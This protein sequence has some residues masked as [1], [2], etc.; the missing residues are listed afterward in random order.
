M[1]QLWENPKTISTI[2]LNADKNDIKKNMANFIVNNLYDNISSLHQKDEQIIYIVTLLLKEEINSLT[3]INNSFLY[4]TC[5]GLILKEFRKRKEVK[6]FFKKI[7][8][9]MIEQFEN[10]YSSENII[11]ET[12][13]IREVIIN[14]LS[15]SNNKKSDNVLD[16]KLNHDEDNKELELFK[17]KYI[18]RSLDKDKINDE[19]IKYKDKDMLEYLLKIINGM[20]SS[21]KYLNETFLQDI[22]SYRESDT[23]MEY[24][25]NSFSQVVDIIDKFFDNLINNIDLCPYSIKCFCKIISILI[26]KKFPKSIKVEQNRFLVIYFFQNLLF[27]MLM[28]PGLDAFINE[29]FI[30]KSINNKIKTI[31]N[32]LNKLLRGN[33]Y[34]KS[35]FTPF[36]WYIIEKM[37]KILEFFNTIC[38]VSLPSF[39]DK[40][41]ND[42]LPE[43]YKYDYFKENPNKTILYRNICFN[44][45]ELYSLVINSEK[46]K[47]KLSIIEQ[48]VLS[49]FKIYIKNLEKLKN[50]E[51]YEEYHMADVSYDIIEK[52][53]IM[54]Y[55]LLTDLINNK[56]FDKILNLQKYNKN[57]FRL[58]ELKIIET[59]EQKIENNIIK[60]KNFFY[61]LLYNYQVLSKNE[62]KVEKLSDIINILKELK[63]KSSISSSIYM[64]NRHIP[65]DWYINS[66]LHYLPKLP[67]IYKEN[68][69]Q[70]LLNEIEYEITNS[71]N[72]LNFEKLTNFLEY[73]KD[74]QKEK[75]YN[76]KVINILNDLEINRIAEEIINEK[77]IYFDF[78]TNDKRNLLFLNMISKNNFSNLFQKNEEEKKMYNNIN[79]FINKFPTFDENKF[80]YNNEYFNIL[81]KL[82][83]PDIIENYFILIKKNLKG[84]RLGNEKRINDINNKLYDYLMDHLYD[85]LFPK[86]F[87]IQDIEIYKNCYKH[88]W[89]EFSNLIKDNKNYI[90]DDYLP[91]T[92]NY[93]KQFEKEK[94]PRKKLDC[95][96]EIFNCI[97]NLAKFNGDEIKGADDEMPLLNYSLI[98]SKPERIYSTCKYVELFLGEKESEIEGS[99][100]TKILGI[101]EKMKK[102]KFED[103]YNLTESDYNYK[104]DMVNKGLL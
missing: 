19:L 8:L 64:D 46:C 36:N 93:F 18:Y 69:Y 66:L 78:N 52:K 25:K 13:E 100:L 9:K 104:C 24:Y 90:F 17:E 99:Q 75:I 37:P 89:V 30:S 35:N 84:K 29:Y 47:E 76:Q 88:M 39:I 86:E 68:D 3:S 16:K 87:L 101:C 96:Q 91:D 54:K 92:I 11:L 103:Y 82:Q 15:S 33:L 22:S 95:L 102:S 94:S 97:Y 77:K 72:E 59:E 1:R 55:F 67:E 81:K 79:Y 58:K 49:K 44:I 57:H 62:F 14:S 74:A 41:L 31:I 50:K 83:I 56:K 38:Q 23:I 45:D 12:N 61:D 32:I 26:K 34:E 70:Q 5:S 80:D 98:Q 43:D 65:L 6:F 40:L 7:I 85:K 4:E 63:T 73:Y 28:N 20:S 2:L 42:E 10:N 51:E 53:R 27:P 71:I 21:N 60:V 48:K